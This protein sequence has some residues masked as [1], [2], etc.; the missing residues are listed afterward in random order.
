MVC[1]QARAPGVVHLY[2]HAS[3]AL[4]MLQGEGKGLI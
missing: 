3:A 2:A 1:T 4:L